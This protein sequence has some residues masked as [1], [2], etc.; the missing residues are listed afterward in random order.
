MNRLRYLLDKKEPTIGTRTVIVWPGL[1]EVLGYTKQYDYVEFLAEYGAFSLHDLDNYA[2]AAELT[3]LST[4][5]K[6]DQEPRTFLAG[7]ALASGIEN[8]LFADI[9]KR[10]DVE[11]AVNAVRAEPKGKSGVR[12]D[13]R[14]GYVMEKASSKDVVKMSDEAVIGLMIEKRSAVVNLEEI[15]SVKGVDFVQFG[16]SDYSMSIG[17]PGQTSDDRV[18]DAELKTIKTALDMNINP[19]VEI[20]EPQEAKRYVELGV[21]DFNLNIDLFILFN[22]WKKKGS[23]LKQILGKT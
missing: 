8:F 3:G 12:L 17:I 23:E 19:R 10:E 16:P 6:L 20:N 11:E 15:L 21:K 22:W 9:R 14:V 18:R 5:I 2:R 7:R 4:M 13:R 1:I